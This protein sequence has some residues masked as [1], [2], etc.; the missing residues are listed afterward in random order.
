[1]SESTESAESTEAESAD[2]VAGP[3]PE[4]GAYTPAVPEPAP[5]PGDPLRGLL[6]GALVAVL[7][8][9][10][11]GIAV[12]VTNYEIGIL[13]VL[14]GYAVGYTVHRVGGVASTGTAVAAAALAAVGISLGFVVTTLAALA[15]F[16][17]IGFFDA[18]NATT[19]T[20]GWGNLLSH[21]VTG[22]DWAFLAIGA[23]AAF[24][25]VARQRRVP[26]GH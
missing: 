10:V 21:S 23:F 18:V 12:Y 19:D 25:L 16:L 14:I 15:K 26:T 22:L 2:P 6:A 7:G 24:R 5:V 4:Y 17:Q 9:I 13:A 3:T 8:A 1:M 20:I 11:W